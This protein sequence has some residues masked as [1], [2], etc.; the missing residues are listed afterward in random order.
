M[1]LVVLGKENLRGSSKKIF[2]RGLSGKRLKGPCKKNLLRVLR[3]EKIKGHCMYQKVGEFKF[4]VQ[5]S[6]FPG[7][8]KYTILFIPYYNIYSEV[9]R[10][11]PI[12]CTI[13]RIHK[14]RA[15]IKDICM[16]FTYFFVPFCNQWTSFLLKSEKNVQR[17]A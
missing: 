11:R 15:V 7:S 3:G 8:E 12:A 14:G 9:S 13:A 17:F 1:T 16:R 2:W 5:S 10:T 6:N 4:L